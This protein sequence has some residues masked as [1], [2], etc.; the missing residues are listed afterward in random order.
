MSAFWRWP[1]ALLALILSGVG[2]LRSL[3]TDDRSSDEVDRHIRVVIERALEQAGAGDVFV[4]SSRTAWVPSSIITV[5]VSM[6]PQVTAHWI[7]PGYRL[8]SARGARAP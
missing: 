3:P 4:L 7:Q 2:G 8:G 6:V 1:C 5:A